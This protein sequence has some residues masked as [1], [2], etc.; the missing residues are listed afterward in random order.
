MVSLVHLFDGKRR[1][2][3]YSSTRDSDLSQP[4]KEDLKTPRPDIILDIIKKNP[5]KASRSY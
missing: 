3:K 5:T 2:P 4:V 1:P